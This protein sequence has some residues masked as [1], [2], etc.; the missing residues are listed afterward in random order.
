MR[1]LLIG[2]TLAFIG[3]ALSSAAA[4]PAKSRSYSSCYCDFGYPDHPCKPVVSCYGEG[5]RCVKSC[6]R[7]PEPR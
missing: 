7:Q 1:I 2:S 6:P 5:G 3:L 4:D